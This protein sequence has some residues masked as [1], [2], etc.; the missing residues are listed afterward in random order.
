MRDFFRFFGDL[1]RLRRARPALRAPGV[2]VS[3]VR[4]FDRV[5]VMHR[6]L[7]GTGEDV[8]V[9]V[10]FD[11]LPKFGYEVGLPFAGTWHE[12]FN[13]DVYDTFPNPAPYGNGGTVEASGPPLDGFAASATLTIPAN[14]ALVLA[15]G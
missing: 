15:R 7:E 10:S 13:S 2:R 1:V 6:W 8:V 4:S 12:L 3:R 11:E 14:G 9:V 5:M